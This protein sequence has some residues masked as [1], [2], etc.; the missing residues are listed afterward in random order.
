MLPNSEHPVQAA[1][2]WEQAARDLALAT[3]RFDAPIDSY[4]VLGNLQSGLIDLHQT[5]TQLVTFHERE[6]HRAATDRG[7]LTAGGELAATAA[8]HLTQAARTLDHATD[9]LMAGFA[10]NGRIAWQPDPVDTVLTERAA[11]LPEASAPHRTD[12]GQ[13][14]APGR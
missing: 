11:R 10:C 5:L 9:E 6:Q 12:P 14:P 4:T 2:A 13:P 1:E 3:R 7:D 8:Q